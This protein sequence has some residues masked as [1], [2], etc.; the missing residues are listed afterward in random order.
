[1]SGPGTGTH[2]EAEIRA[3]PDA[4]TRVLDGAGARIT[5]LAAALRTRGGGP[6]SVLIAAR[7]SSDNVARYAQYVFG[8][9]LGLPVALAAPSLES[10]YSAGAVP[11][12]P[13][14]L[15]IGISQ[16]GSS[17]DV[18][19]VLDAARTAG[20]P[21]VA[22][23]NDGGSPLA[24]AAET[25]I[26]LGVGVERSVAA[27]KTYTAS[28]AVIA[29]LAAALRD[30]TGPDGGPAGGSGGGDTESLRRVRALP[31]LVEQ[32]IADAFAAVDPVLDAAAG[33]TGGAVPGASPGTAAGVASHVVVLGR[34]YNIATAMEIALKVRELTGTV[35][36][37]FS[38]ADYLHGPIAAVPPGTL[39]VAVAPAGRAHA[40]VLDTVRTLR[41]RGTRSLII[42]ESP[43]AAFPLPPHLPEW[44]SPVVAVIPGQILAL[45]MAER[46]GRTVDRP[47]GLQKVTRTT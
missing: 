24:N 1:M 22:I 35:A 16:S 45:R 46:A 29:A 37:G 7:G 13:G 3:Q 38:T 21:T 9:R 5:R 12:G 6:R 11:R 33:V 31:A 15:V 27:T 39:A 17:P 32:V 40:S 19:S 25:V 47:E 20:T 4:I 8:E 28:L 14:A 30:G 44:L 41:E 42:G 2:L 10:L 23:T 18:V 34:G 26:E 36:E 43:D